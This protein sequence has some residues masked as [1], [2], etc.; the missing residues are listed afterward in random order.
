MINIR[1][2]AK[3]VNL[4]LRTQCDKGRTGNRIVRLK[5]IGAVG[6]VSFTITI[7][8]TI[9]CIRDEITIEIRGKGWIQWKSIK[10]IRHTVLIGVPSN[11]GISSR[12]LNDNGPVGILLRRQRRI[13]RLVFCEKLDLVGS[14]YYKVTK[15]TRP[16]SIAVLIRQFKTDDI[17]NR[18]IRGPGNLIRRIDHRP[19]P[20]HWRRS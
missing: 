14:L 19:D 4:S 8:I 5:L 15:L 16:V 6:L 7:H 1:D 2:F 3:T 11:Y 13:T 10:T 18:S 17:Q 9:Q 20:R 12:C